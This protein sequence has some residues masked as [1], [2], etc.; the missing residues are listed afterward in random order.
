[1]KTFRA[2][3]GS[4]TGIVCAGSLQSCGGGYHAGPQPA[5][6][7]LIVDLAAGLGAVS[8]GLDYVDIHDTNGK[9]IKQLVAGG[10]LNAYDAAAG[11]PL[12]VASGIN[13]GAD[14]VYGRIELTTP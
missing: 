9:L 11:T 10:A 8:V 5:A 2:A 14:R 1:M 12:G 4:L 6:R 3:G 13:S 7:P